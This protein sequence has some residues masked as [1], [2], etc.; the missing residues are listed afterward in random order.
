[1]PLTPEERR[2]LQPMCDICDKEPA[3]EIQGGEVN[4]QHGLWF[5]CKSCKQRI[6]DERKNKQAS[7]L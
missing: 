3:S 5:C 7:S 6:K 1:M 2:V 4:G